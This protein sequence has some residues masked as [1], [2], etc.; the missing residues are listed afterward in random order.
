MVAGLIAGFARLIT[1]AVAEWHVQPHSDRVRVYFA[2]HASHADFA[3]IWAALPA[4]VRARTRP[5]AA[6]DYWQGSRLRRYLVAQVFRAVLIDRA[7]GGPAAT[8]Q[9]VGAL[10]AGDSLIIFPEGTRGDG[11]VIAPF[12]SGLYHLAVAVPEAELI[13]VRL[14]NLNRVLP[15]GE[16]IPV[17]VIARLTFGRPL[18]LAEGESKESLLARAHAAVASLDERANPD[19]DVS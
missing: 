18:T 16:T 10:T 8:E 19:R 7:G 3:T 15:K 9:M 11:R 4:D 5:V 2:N 13:P 14:V 6:A 12:R 1:G 17:P